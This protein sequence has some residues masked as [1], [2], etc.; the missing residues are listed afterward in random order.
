[1]LPHFHCSLRSLC[2]SL[3]LFVFSMWSIRKLFLSFYLCFL[4]LPLSLSLSLSYTHTIS[5]SLTHTQLV[6]VSLCLPFFVF[7][8]H[9]L[10][11]SPYTTNVR[12]SASNL[13]GFTPPPRPLHTPLATHPSITQD[14]LA[15]FD[16][17]T[18]VCCCC[19]LQFEFNTVP[20]PGIQQ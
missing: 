18:E 4:L 1:M 12:V 16:H 7:L 6:F 5:L 3:S 13:P 14:F 8:S 10:S 19:A 9:T 2:L 11:Q 15:Q 17:Q 20:F